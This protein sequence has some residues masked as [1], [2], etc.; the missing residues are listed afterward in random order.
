MPWHVEELGVRVLV[1]YVLLELVEDVLEKSERD[2]RLRQICPVQAIETVRAHDAT[3]E[4]GAVSLVIVNEEVIG[5]QVRSDHVEQPL[6]LVEVVV[7]ELAM[8]VVA[9][10]ANV[11]VVPHLQQVVHLLGQLLFVLLRLAQ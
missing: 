8:E 11:P 3:L 2:V 9:V 1:Q 10:A 5:V 4:E 7:A 6:D